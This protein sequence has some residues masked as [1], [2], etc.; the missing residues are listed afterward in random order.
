MHVLCGILSSMP[1][2]ETP[3]GPRGGT[4]TLTAGGLLKKTLYFDPEEWAALR[5]KSYEED[6]P[7]S[8]ILRELVRS[9]LGL[10]GG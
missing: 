3:T 4:T 5:K 1:K 2:K 10:E 6:R 8:E 9:A 7:I